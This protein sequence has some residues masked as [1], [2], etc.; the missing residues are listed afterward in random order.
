[1]TSNDLELSYKSN[2]EVVSVIS[3]NCRSLYYVSH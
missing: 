1:M 2:T 3:H